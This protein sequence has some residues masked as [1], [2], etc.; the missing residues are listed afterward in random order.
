MPSNAAERE[1]TCRRFYALRAFPTIIGCIDCTHIKIKKC[2]GSAAQYY[3]NRKGY[4]SLNVQVTCD[5]DLKIQDIVARWRGS[6]HDARIFNECS[7]KERFEA[8]EFRGKRLLG[9]SG[10]KLEPYLLTPVLRA[11]SA[12]EERYNTAHIA[13]RNTVERCFGVWKARF[14]CL[15]QGMTVKLQN[16]KTTVIALAVLHNI[17]IMHNDLVPEADEDGADEEEADEEVVVAAVSR[18]ANNAHLR[19]FIHR[20]FQ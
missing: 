6:T 18:A 8:G 13:T 1:E 16:V 19:A 15:L 2:G 7:L 12:S 9:D 5:A 10:Y 17:A 11:Q 14:R 3:I 4:Y 20:H